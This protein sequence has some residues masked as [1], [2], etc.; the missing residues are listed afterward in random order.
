MTWTQPTITRP[1]TDKRDEL[2]LEL[3]KETITDLD[4]NAETA[5]DV[6]GGLSVGGTNATVC[7]C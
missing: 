7:S 3:G 5:D 2:D 4:V 6:R 1:T